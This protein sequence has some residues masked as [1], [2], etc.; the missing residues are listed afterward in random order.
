M[1]WPFGGR[2]VH[3]AARAPPA[4]GRRYRAVLERFFSE[5][6]LKGL[7]Q[8]Q[9]DDAD[10]TRHVEFNLRGNADTTPIMDAAVGRFVAELS[11]R[12]EILRVVDQRVHLHPLFTG[13]DRS[14]GDN[15]EQVIKTL[16]L[17]LSSIPSR[18]K[19]LRPLT[20]Q[21]WM[22]GLTLE[23]EFPA[24]KAAR[25]AKKALEH[26]DEWQKQPVDEHTANQLMKELDAF[27][28]ELNTSGSELELR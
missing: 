10:K 25:F 4:L 26:L 18:E 22:A 19:V 27:I 5:A 2:G 11:K 17:F 21:K 1:I 13:F 3:E 28:Q 23:F 20:F 9:L 15:T 16:E 14:I 12:I 8:R 7:L 6:E 24:K